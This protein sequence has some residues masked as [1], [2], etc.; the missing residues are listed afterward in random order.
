MALEIRYTLTEIL[1][2]CY[3]KPLNMIGDNYCVL[4]HMGLLKPLLIGVVG[5]LQTHMKAA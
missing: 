5:F 3:V 1:F 4:I 2:S